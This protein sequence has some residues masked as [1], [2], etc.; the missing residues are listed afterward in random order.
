MR[1]K[2]EYYQDNLERS[3]SQY[4]IDREGNV[5][6]Y[7]GD[8]NEEIVS[9]H[10][11]IAYDLFPE[12]KDPEGILNRLG[13]IQVGSTVYHVPIIY[14]KPSQAQINKLFELELYTA[15]TFLYNG[16]YI[17]YHKYQALCE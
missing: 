1:H 9:M 2:S 13:W 14:R 5:Q 3:N 7:K 17:N 6:K 15:L 16:R 10:F 4:Y 12:S 11:R 8:L